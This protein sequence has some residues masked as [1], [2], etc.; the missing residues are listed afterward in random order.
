M[1]GIAANARLGP[2]GKG[3]ARLATPGRC[4]RDYQQTRSRPSALAAVQL[5]IGLGQQFGVDQIMS[6]RIGGRAGQADAD[7]DRLQ[8]EVQ[9]VQRQRVTALALVFGV[10]VC[11]LQLGPTQQATDAALAPLPTDALCWQE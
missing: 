9:V 11:P 2:G 7:R 3:R 5:P 1:G 10:A 8:V 6:G 4:R